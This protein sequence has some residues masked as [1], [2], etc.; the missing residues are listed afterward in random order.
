MAG[1]KKID[2]ANDNGNWGGKRPN[3]GRPSEGERLNIRKM[4][5]DSIDPNFVTEKIFQL[6]D[7]GDYRAID[8]Y[9]KYR[10]GTAVQAID[11]NVTGST[12][13]NF[14]LADVIKFKDEN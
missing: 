11:L 4:L 13:V 12:D 8:L 1:K 2:G 9:M 6:I 3:S 5:D 10:V 14:N 7:N